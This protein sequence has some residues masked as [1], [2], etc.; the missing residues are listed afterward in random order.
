MTY[1]S[2]LQPR[3]YQVEALNRMQERESFALLMAMRTGKT[4][5]LLDDYGRLELE[6]KCN[7]LLVVAPGGVYETWG[8]ACLDHL[9][10]DLYKRA[11]I[12]VW[13]GA[14]TKTEKLRIEAMS[15]FDGPRILIINIEALSRVKRAQDV[16]IDFVKNRN[17]RSMAAVDECFTTDTLISTTEGEKIISSLK[18][19]DQVIS[20]VGI[21]KVRSILKKS[22]SV[23]LHIRLSN[24]NIIKT[25]PNHP[26]FTEAGWICAGN[27]DKGTILHEKDTIQELCLLQKEKANSTRQQILRDILLS[28]MEDETAR[29]SCKSFYPRTQSENEQSIKGEETRN[30]FMEQRSSYAGDHK[31]EIECK[32]QSDR[33]STEDNRRE[34]QA[35]TKASEDFAE[36]IRPAME[37]RACHKIGREASRLSNMLQSGSWK[38]EKEACDRMRR[39][40]PQQQ[41]FKSDGHEKREQNCRVWVENIKIEKLRNP[42]DVY[43]IE[44]EGNP[45]FFA[46][47]VL[48]H[49]ST[50][51][52]N[53][54]SGQSKIMLNLAGLFKYRRILTGLI[55]PRSPLD[56]YAQYYFLNPSILG[57]RSF[58]SFR[59]RFCIL[60]QVKFGAIDPATG[61]R[62]GRPTTLVVA[63]R[64]PEELQA[65]I[66][67]HSFRV[68]LE[69]ANPHLPPKIYQPRLVKM[70]AE[71]FRIYNELKLFANAELDALSHVTAV[72][73]ISQIMK[74]HQVL[75]G[76]VKDEN[77]V[78]KS[79][80]ENRT[81]ELLSLLDEYE[82]KAIIW[83]S[84]HAD[85]DKICTALRNEYGS[86]AVA[87]FWGGNKSV[88]ED[89]EVRF[90]TDPRCRFMVA[91]ASAGGRGRTWDVADMLVYYSNTDN[92]E[93]RL[94]SEERAESVTRTR[95][96]LIVDLYVENT[97]ETKII[98]ALREKINMS[99]VINGD[100]YKEWLI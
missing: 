24:G 92:L 6:G 50:I 59:A 88:R 64:D 29:N 38:R 87:S 48:V 39:N 13:K 94:Q 100:N 44:L 43:D 47:G 16:V 99:T 96:T 15:K 56:L 30:S 17:R 62:V 78:E 27:L 1:L 77:G 80:P 42:I 81:S 26:F 89:D 69:D 40:E 18:I 19:G 55:A 41:I 25:T 71:Q 57:F 33:S 45:H 97:V 28:E 73:V 21:S 51:I 74:L 66:A 52:K 7:D 79:I 61:E 90:K 85:I 49:N 32:T 75:L 9:S 11:F 34:W 22:S 93:H 63:H 37:T 82:G 95:S 2:K 31:K 46:E 54:S 8:K 23:I 5:T 83:G 67:P 36:N 53:E 10:D 84:Y 91:T 68:T 35:I 65:R 3:P 76:H 20:S 58:Y 12:H 14:H 4:K 60:K 98:K 86:D 70:T 72:N